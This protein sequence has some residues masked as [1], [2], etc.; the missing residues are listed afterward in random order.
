MRKLPALL[1][2]A[3]AVAAAPACSLVTRQARSVRAKAEC[4]VPRHDTDTT[5]AGRTTAGEVIC[6]GGTPTNP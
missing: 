2:C 4:E 5:S 1:L 6:K 3:A